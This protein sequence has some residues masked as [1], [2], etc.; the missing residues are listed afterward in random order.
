MVEITHRNPTPRAS[1]TPIGK[2]M[3]YLSET[4]TWLK[5]ESIAEGVR[6]V[7]V[8]DFW[9]LFYVEDAL[10][11]IVQW[12]YDN[13][14]QNAYNSGAD[15]GNQINNEILGWVENLRTEAMSLIGKLDRARSDAEKWLSDHEKRIKELEKQMGIPIKMPNWVGILP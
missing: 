8:L 3:G 7:W 10:V 13:V 14:Y 6:A 12:A 4:Q 2:M 15:Q 1:D 9:P 5:Y 11:G